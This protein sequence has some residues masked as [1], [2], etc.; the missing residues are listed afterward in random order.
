MGMRVKVSSLGGAW[1]QT[2]L[3]VVVM[4]GLVVEGWK[5]GYWVARDGH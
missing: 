1:P 4:V 2:T 3:C 5:T